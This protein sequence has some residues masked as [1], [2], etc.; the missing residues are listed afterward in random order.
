MV[1]WMMDV[2]KNKLLYQFPQFI[3]VIEFLLSIYNV[4]D[5][6]KCRF[7]LIDEEYLR[8]MTCQRAVHPKFGL[9]MN[10][11]ICS[12]VIKTTLKR[13]LSFFLQYTSYIYH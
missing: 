10:A 13:C 7:I 12:A 6:I 2:F 11:D 3:Y 8:R 4:Y 5:N 1:P 9:S